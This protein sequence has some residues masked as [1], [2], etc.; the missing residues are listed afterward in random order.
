MDQELARRGCGARM[1][2]VP[3]GGDV[4][5]RKGLTSDRRERFRHRHETMQRRAIFLKVL[6]QW[7]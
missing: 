7:N 6:A 3:Q 5:P 2:E 4:L 1:R